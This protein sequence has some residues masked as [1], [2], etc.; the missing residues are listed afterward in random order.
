MRPYRLFAGA[1]TAAGFSAVGIA[2]N[3]VP[4]LVN[5]IGFIKC[6]Y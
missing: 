6:F 5:D 3:G 1:Q 2:H 4:L